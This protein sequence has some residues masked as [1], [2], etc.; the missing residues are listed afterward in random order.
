M[1]EIEA[2]CTGLDRVGGNLLSLWES[3]KEIQVKGI[4]ELRKLQEVESVF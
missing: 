3:L 4:S 2:M 1:T